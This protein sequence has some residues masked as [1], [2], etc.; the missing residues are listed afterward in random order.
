MDMR[1]RAIGLSWLKEGDKAQ[2]QWA[3]NH[4]QAKGLIGK[5]YDNSTHEGLLSVGVELEAMKDKGVTIIRAMRDAWRQKKYRA[6]TKGRK[7]YSFTLPINVKNKLDALAKSTATNKT[8]ATPVL[9]ALIEDATTDVAEQK[10]LLK[11]TNE[12]NKAALQHLKSEVTEYKLV[13]QEK[14][15]HLNQCLAE[16]CRHEAQLKESTPETLESL[17][18]ALYQ[19]KKD[20]IE[21]AINEA[22]AKVPGLQNKLRKLTRAMERPIQRAGHTPKGNQPTETP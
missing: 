9:I 11:A 17:I 13:I 10:K 3:H 12:R 4:L 20:A 8:T 7:P 5:E 15:K 6:P 18:A 14:E 2:Q 16:L 21:N 1:K 22:I 19:Q